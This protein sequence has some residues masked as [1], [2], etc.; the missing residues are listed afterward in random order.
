MQI[1]R[2]MQT[3][4]S[5]TLV[6]VLLA[7][8][9]AAC[10]GVPAPDITVATPTGPAIATQPAPLT[11]VLPPVDGG[12]PAVPPVPS[13]QWTEAPAMTIDP[14]KLYFATF[15]TAKGD[16]K[17]E[18]FAKTAP[19]T[20]NNFV[21]LSKEG[22][23]DDTTFHRVIAD[24]MA[25]GGDPTG[26]GTGGPGY[27][28]EDE[29]DISKQFDEAGYLAMANA[30]PNTNG[31]QFFITTAA[32]PWLNGA[33]TIFGKVVEG[34]DV[35][36]SLTLRD[37]Q[38]DAATPGDALVTVEISEGAVSLLPPPTATPTPYPPVMENGR[39]LAKKAVADREKL[40]NSA[41]AL[42]IDKA[43]KY[44][45][46]IKTSKGDIEVELFADSAPQSVNSFVLLSKLGYYDEF[47][48]NFTQPGAFV[49]TGSPAGQPASDVGYTLPLEASTT[50]THTLGVMGL[51]YLA[52]KKGSSG[53]QF[54]FALGDLPEYDGQFSVMGRITKG[55]DVAIALTMEDK[56]VMIEITEK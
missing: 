6:G 3:A 11:P 45:A 30:G 52:D 4:L 22:F 27:Q 44:S 51:Y 18:L 50:V 54:Y 34:M 35:V 37:P 19:I 26:A 31:S 55:T 15:K 28:F 40:Y 1:H 14:T 46:T 29:I 41:P 47:P 43:K 49:L 16:I 2:R 23:Y 20:V 32:T 5:L 9:L 38:Q 56:I 25:Q 53:S 13:Q 33:H 12:T 24:F 42:L 10:S 39:P 36:K 7:V 48:I 17:V 21:F 8:L